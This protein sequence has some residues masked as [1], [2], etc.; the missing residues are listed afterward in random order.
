V[1]AVLIARHASLSQLLM[2]AAAPLPIVAWGGFALGRLQRTMFG[3][4]VAP[5][6]DSGLVAK[7][8]EARFGES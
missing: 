1:A 3:A 7:L 8:P 2:I 6:G 4:P 5:L